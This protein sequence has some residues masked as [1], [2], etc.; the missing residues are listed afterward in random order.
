MYAHVCV[1]ARAR[2][3]VCVRVYVRACC[4]FV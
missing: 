1:R 4:V 3:R 2:M